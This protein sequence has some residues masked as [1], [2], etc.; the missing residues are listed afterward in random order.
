VSGRV[1]LLS[2]HLAVQQ[3]MSGERPDKAGHCRIIRN[4]T[5]SRG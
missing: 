1:E 4:S 2:V 3:R 5:G